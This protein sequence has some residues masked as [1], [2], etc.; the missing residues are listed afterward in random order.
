MKKTGMRLLLAVL[1]F[2]L[3]F[4]ASAFSAL[5]AEE[6]VTTAVAS[7]EF[8]T[9]QGEAFTT[10]IYIPDNANILDFEL[11]LNYDTDLL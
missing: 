2:V 10:T 8:H 6:E 1:V 5:A 3:V 7:S 11:T 4:S 9:H